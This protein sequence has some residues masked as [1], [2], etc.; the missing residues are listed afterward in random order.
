M[1]EVR[2]PASK[3][4]IIM[5]KIRRIMNFQQQDELE[6]ISFPLNILW[7]KTEEIEAL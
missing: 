4:A 2:N 3:M 7:R 5:C 1:L 6:G